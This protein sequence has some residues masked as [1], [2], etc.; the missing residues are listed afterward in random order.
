MRT[1]KDASITFRYTYKKENVTF[2]DILFFAGISYTL[3]DNIFSP[4]SFKA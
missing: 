3:V 1:F 2:N 4:I